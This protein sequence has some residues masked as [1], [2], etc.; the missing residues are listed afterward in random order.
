LR[1][2]RNLWPKEPTLNSDINRLERRAAQRFSLHLPLAVHF[3]GRTVPG[4]TQ[5]LTGRGIFFFA[6]TSL[7][8]GTVVELIFIMPSEITLAESM[9]MRCRGRVLRVSDSGHQRHGF[10]VQLDSHEYL[11]ADEPISRFVRAS[12]TSAAA[13]SH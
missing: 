2:P 12:A 10:A 3:G 1:R 7:P 13:L 9:P 5:D 11:S 6:E 4:F 8:E